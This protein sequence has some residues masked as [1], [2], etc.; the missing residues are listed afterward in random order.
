MNPLKRRPYSQ[1]EPHNPSSWIEDHEPYLNKFHIAGVDEVGRGPL[2]GP[3]VAAACLFMGPVEISGV[4]R[5]SKKLPSHKRAIT[6]RELLA[7]PNVVVGFGEVSPEE[8]DRINILQATLKAMAIAVSKL[9]IDPTIVFVDGIHYP[10]I[11]FHGVTL[12]KG[13]SRSRLIASASIL[14]KER[15]DA[16][17]REYDALYPGYGFAANMGYGTELHRKALKKLGPTPIHRLSFAPVKAVLK[18]L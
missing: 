16:M 13:D 12:K 3:V 17:M 2:A 10:N 5:D 1:R 18:L 6:A 7:H 15:R 9:S 11:P 14:A 4:I 8:I